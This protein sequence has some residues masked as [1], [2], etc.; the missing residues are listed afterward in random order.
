ML[1]LPNY[2]NLAELSDLSALAGRQEFEY[3]R[4]GTV[5]LLVGLVAYM[6][7]MWLECLKQNNGEHFRPAVN[8]LLE[9]FAWAKRIHLIMGN[10]PSHTSGESLKFFH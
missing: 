10:G 3:I 7:Q 9:G 1:P 5:N 8:R 6:G 2:W 4:H